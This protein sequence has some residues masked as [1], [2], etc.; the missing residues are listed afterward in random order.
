MYLFIATTQQVAQWMKQDLFSS[1]IS[2]EG[3]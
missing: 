2:L 1:G 3:V